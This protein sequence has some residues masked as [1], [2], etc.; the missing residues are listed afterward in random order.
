[1]VKSPKLVSSPKNFHLRIEGISLKADKFY[2]YIFRKLNSINPIYHI[3][4]FCEARSNNP[5]VKAIF[6]KTHFTEDTRDFTSQNLRLWLIG[7][8]EFNFQKTS[9]VKKKIQTTI[10]TIQNQL[11]IAM[12]N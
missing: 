7:L 5:S 11:C 4:K 10:K 1:M 3:L 12:A 2:V 9:R 8:M 6:M